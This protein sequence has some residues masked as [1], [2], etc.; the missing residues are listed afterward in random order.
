MLTHGD[1]L[2]ISED[3]M[4]T[5]Q[6]YLLDLS[7]LSLSDIPIAG[8]KNASLGEMLNKLSSRG[9]RVP[10][11]FAV[12]VDGYQEFIRQDGLAELIENETD[13]Y[14]ARVQTLNTTGRVLRTAILKSP[15]PLALAREITRAYNGMCGLDGGPASVAV[16]SSAT[17]EDLPDASFAGQQDTYLNVRG[18]SDVL[19]ACVR[20]Y[21]SL[22]TDRAIAYREERGYDHMSVS[23]SIGIQR[24][25]RSDLGSSGVMFTLDPETGFDKVVV[26][27]S[28]FGLGEAV[29]QGNV[30]PDEFA[31]FKPGL[32]AGAAS[33]ILH[34]KLGDKK[35]KVIFGDGRGDDIVTVDTTAAERAS[36]SLTDA[37][38]LRL[39][40][41]AMLIEKSYGRP[42]DIEWAK[43]GASGDLYIVQAR[44]ETVISQ[45]SAAEQVTY[46]VR[47]HGKTLAE[48][49][50]VGAGAASGRAIRIN[51]P[52]EIDRFEPGCVL[53]TRNTDP[54]W[55]PI[56]SQAAAIVTEVGGRT[57]HAAIV[58]RELGKAAVVG[59]G[60]AAAA[61][62]DGAIVT[63]SCANGVTGYVYEGAADIVVKRESLADLPETR[64]RIMLNVAV[65]DNAMKWHG[66]NAGGIGLARL[67]FIFGSHVRAHPLALLHPE[68]VTDPEAR[69]QIEAMTAGYDCPADYMVDRLASGIATIAASV[70]PE[71]AIVRMSDFKSNE[72]AELIGGRDFEPD[73]E[74]PMIGYRGA[75]RYYS[76]EYRPA[77]EL[78]CK[79]MVRAREEMGLDNIIPMI[80]FCRTPQ[81]AD[82][83]LEIMAANG[84]ERGVDGLQVYVMAELPS[85]VFLAKEFAQ[86]FDGFSI[87]SNDLTQLVLGVDRDSTRIAGLFDERDPAV[88]AAISQVIATAKECGIKVGICGQGPSDHIDFAEFLVEQGIDSISLNPDTYAATKRRIAVVEQRA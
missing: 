49:L 69:R 70:Y 53:V 5:R 67:E 21:A 35:V 66:L 85:N 65:P 13:M 75:S 32:A 4:K 24:M 64:T 55:V 61:I 23:L 45:K 56:M 14:R 82:K 78:E 8:G 6:R 19:R 29:V 28:A 54:D 31:I 47:S 33:P 87:G 42:M 1:A 73:E 2:I 3:T 7:E 83:V 37:E 26:I 62:P 50:S 30:T 15:L 20:A 43:D 11:G 39:A 74:N 76:P 72:Y 86:R 84:L 46:E 9:I 79:A 18:A 71:P 40:R 52:T 60:D 16:R 36:L 57:S 80:P 25:V 17:A 88:L 44:P 41:W 58:S 10:G 59:T 77:Y 12:L 51:S 34:R 27:N 22:F 38:A 63:V 48:G 68:K 81:E